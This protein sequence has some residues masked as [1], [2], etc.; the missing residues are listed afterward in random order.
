MDAVN[1][2]FECRWSVH[3]TGLPSEFV[4]NVSLLL[5]PYVHLP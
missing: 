1:G 5:N 3:Y 2:G 4:F